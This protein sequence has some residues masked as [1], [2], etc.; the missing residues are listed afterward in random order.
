MLSVTQPLNG[1]KLIDTSVVQKADAYS[2]SFS[3][4]V[5]Q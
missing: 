2:I 4:L 1:D 3:T 5:Y